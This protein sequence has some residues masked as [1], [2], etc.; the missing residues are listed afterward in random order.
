MVGDIV[1]DEYTMNRER[2]GRILTRLQEHEWA[3][4]NTKGREYAQGD[5]DALANFKQ[6]GEFVHTQCPH[7][8]GIHSIGTLAAAMVYLFKHFAALAAYTGSGKVLSESI[9]G[10]VDDFRLYAALFAAIVEE[11]ND[12]DATDTV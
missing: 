4:N 6:A 12:G 5:D 9:E 3:I 2:F 10:R 7:C 8:G 1:G 11:L